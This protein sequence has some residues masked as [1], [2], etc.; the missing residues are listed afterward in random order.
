MSTLLD[1]RQRHDRALL[2]AE[3]NADYEKIAALAYSLWQ[4]HGCPEGT[5]QEDWLAA[6]QQ[7]RSVLKDRATAA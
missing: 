2:N 7:I 3:Q 6:E 5:A 1:Q 4:A